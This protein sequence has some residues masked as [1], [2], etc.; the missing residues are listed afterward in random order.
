MIYLVYVLF[1][2]YLLTR[3]GRVI[4]ASR[5]L[6]VWIVLLALGV[7]MVDPNLIL[8]V[9][10]LFGIQVVSNL[11]FA[12]MLLF[13][14]FEHLTSAAEQTR[15]Q[16]QLRRMIARLASRD[17][18]LPARASPASPRA[19]VVV[20][21]YNE[22]ASIAGVVRELSLLRDQSDWAVDAV[23]VDDGSM[24]DTAAAARREA[25]AG[26]SVV[27]HAVNCG[28]GGVLMTGFLIALEHDYEYVVQCD[29]DG[30]H[31][32]A[33]ISELLRFADHKK[34]DLLVGSRFSQRAHEDESTTLL[35]RVGGRLISIALASFGRGAQVTDPTSGFRVH[36]R[37]AAALLAHKMPD[38]YPE[39][40]SIA[41]CTIER[42]KIGETPVRMNAR[43]AGESSISGWKSAV[44]MVKVLTSLLSFRV[45]HAFGR[46]GAI[47]QPH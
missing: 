32:V 13:L 19:L 47:R 14:L 39:P 2:G 16:R 22:G 8:P 7:I 1:A 25:T 28:V 27:S 15:S 43:Q 20:P 46:A 37:R 35:R 33:H 30:Q 23:I 45:R 3:F 44:F 34:L 17:Y 10:E 40:E 29:G 12:T 9:A 18:Q 5:A 11:V 4:T 24:D 36:S 31:P 42:L 21:A 26:I 6:P 41:L 38:E